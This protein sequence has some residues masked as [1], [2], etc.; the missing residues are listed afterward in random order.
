MS[1]PV[2]RRVRGSVLRLT[3]DRRV[4]L[5]VGATLMA[6]AVALAVGKFRWESWLTDGSGLVLGATGAARLAVALAGRRPDWVD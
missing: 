4:A 2:L 5:P 6:P 1:A 3:L